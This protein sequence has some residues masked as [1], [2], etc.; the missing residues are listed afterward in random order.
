V[1]S[2]KHKAKNVSCAKS[3]E[4]GLSSS[5]KL[6]SAGNKRA[7]YSLASKAPSHREHH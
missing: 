1:A 5:E 2:E 7:I 6:F 3:D 4:Q